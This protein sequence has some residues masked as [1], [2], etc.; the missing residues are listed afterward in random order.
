MDAS[1]DPNKFPEAHL[2]SSPEAISGKART[3]YVIQSCLLQFSTLVVHEIEF[4]TYI[5]EK[6]RRIKNL[7]EED[8]SV[9]PWWQFCQDQSHKI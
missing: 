2:T 8:S 4:A 7:P 3:C 1:D 9:S 6:N 5:G